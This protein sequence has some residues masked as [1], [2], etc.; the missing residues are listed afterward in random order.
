MI[1]DSGSF[2]WGL[3]GTNG[4]APSGPSQATLA[5]RGPC[6]LK[7]LLATPRS[8]HPGAPEPP[9]PHLASPAQDSVDKAQPLPRCLPPSSTSKITAQI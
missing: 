9:R 5:S 7:A 6:V 8:V 4:A 2:G 1:R 3:E